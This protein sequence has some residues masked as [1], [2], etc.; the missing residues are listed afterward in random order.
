MIHNLC[1]DK[2]FGDSDA[3]KRRSMD[4]VLVNSDYETICE[5]WSEL[6]TWKTYFREIETS[7][8]III[9]HADHCKWKGAEI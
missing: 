2:T 9:S 5:E 8:W 4:H 7:D 6:F 3:V 1:V